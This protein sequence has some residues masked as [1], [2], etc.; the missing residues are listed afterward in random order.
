MRYVLLCC[1]LIFMSDFSL[2]GGPVNAQKFEVKVPIKYA[3]HNLTIFYVSGRRAFISLAGSKP[4]IRKVFKISGPFKIKAGSN[5]KT[6][7][8]KIPETE[9]MTDR[10]ENFNYI[11]CVVHSR[12]NEVVALK[13]VNGMI[14][15][16]QELSLGQNSSEVFDHLSSLAVSR[17]EL[18][19]NEVVNLRSLPPT[20]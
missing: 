13:N 2:A 5:S 10:W 3:G 7:Y 12:E 20:F 16:G 18:L 4:H 6:A 9:F 14:P 17:E 1:L 19:V 11:V 8:A 15:E